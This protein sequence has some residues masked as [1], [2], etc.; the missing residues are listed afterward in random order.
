MEYWKKCK[1]SNKKEETAKSWLALI[2]K[3]LTKQPQFKTLTMNDTKRL[4]RL[5]L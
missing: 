4:D 3:F 1:E 5:V 2:V